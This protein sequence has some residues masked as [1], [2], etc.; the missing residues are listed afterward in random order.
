MYFPILRFSLCDVLLCRGGRSLFRLCNSKAS[1]RPVAGG[2]RRSL[3]SSGLKHSRRYVAE[4]ISRRRSTR[5]TLVVRDP[6]HRCCDLCRNLANAGQRGI[7]AAVRD[8]V[9]ADERR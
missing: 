6:G 5:E 3:S 9:V 8:I 7:K 2:L 4:E 1:C